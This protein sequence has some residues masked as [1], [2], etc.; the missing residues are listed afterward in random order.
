VANAVDA[1]VSVLRWV[2][3]KGRRVPGFH[4]NRRCGVQTPR[5]WYISGR[6]FMMHPGQTMAFGSGERT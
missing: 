1:T 2:V 5:R 6:P 3:W 4:G